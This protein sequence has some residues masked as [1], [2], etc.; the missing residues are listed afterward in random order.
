[1]ITRWQELKRRRSLK[2]LLD[3]EARILDDIGLSAEEIYWA[4]A[5]PLC[6]DAIARL[7][8][9]AAA[10]RAKTLAWRRLRKPVVGLLRW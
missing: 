6:E 8:S 5:L 2:R 3:C 1:V 10:R 9:R 4:L 7:Q